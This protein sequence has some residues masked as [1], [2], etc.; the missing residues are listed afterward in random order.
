M[1]ILT[2]LGISL[3]LAMDAFS[4]SVVAGAKLKTPT[5]RQYFRLSFHF[6]LFQFMM[7]I[8]GYYSGV[9]IASIICCYDHWIALAILSLIGLKMIWES[10]RK[11]PDNDYS[12]CRDPS[13]G[14]TLIMLSIATSIDAAAIGFS[15]AALGIPVL[16]PSIIIGIVC[17]F[18]SAFGILLGSKIG[19]H[20]DV[21]A[22]R[23]GGIVLILIGIKILT[24]H[25][26]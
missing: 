1:N 20:I 11:R 9:M 16:K 14:L 13:R 23:A 12:D 24:E 6:G 17:A 15:L 10:F 22:E 25:I 4:V 8:L 19:T 26:F 7:P 18:C 2:V 3:S 21:W 5:P